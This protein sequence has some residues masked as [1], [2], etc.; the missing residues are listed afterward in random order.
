MPG[1][2]GR[3]QRPV[4][5]DHPFILRHGRESGSSIPTGL[6]LSSTTMRRRPPSSRRKIRKRCAGSAAIR[7]LNCCST[8]CRGLPPGHGGRRPGLSRD[9]PGG[10]R[11]PYHDSRRIRRIRYRGGGHGPG[12]DHAHRAT[13][14]S[15]TRDH[16][17]RTAG[18]DR[19][20]V[21]AKD[22]ILFIIGELGAEYA[23]Y[24]VVEFCGP[25]LAK[26]S[27][28][29]RMALCNMTTEMG[30]KGQLYPTG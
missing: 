12:G 27:V 29:E 9:D 2:P 16:P 4:S 11:F 1:R 24:K 28:S 15:G 22:I 17:G 23:I 13:V 6:P 30:A 21:Y 20:G 19:Q 10:H 14:V 26:L 8:S 25:V 7:A 5:S 3:S 18:D